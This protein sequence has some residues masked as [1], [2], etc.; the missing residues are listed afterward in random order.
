M[1]ALNKA[2]ILET[3]VIQTIDDVVHDLNGCRVFSKIDFKQGYH[4]VSFHPDSK[5]LTTFS[6]PIGLYR[7][8]RLN[9]GISCGAEIFQKKVGDATRGIPCVKIISDDIYVCGVGDDDHDRNL[10]HLFQQLQE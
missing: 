4:Q 1:R 5:P 8:R 6:T 9:F 7:Y 2:I 3:H 10:R